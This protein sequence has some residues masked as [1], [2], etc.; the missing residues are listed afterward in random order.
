MDS[1]TA[2]PTI[3]PPVGDTNEESAVVY[4]S[5]KRFIKIIARRLNFFY[6]NQQ[7]LV[8][9]N[10][11]FARNQVTAIIE[12]PVAAHQFTSAATTDF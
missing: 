7:S 3:F 2:N 6:G 9:N 12:P 1:I 8:D 4:S 10:L 5:S 11:E